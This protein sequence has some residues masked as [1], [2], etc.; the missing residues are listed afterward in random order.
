MTQLLSE[1]K[2]LDLIE[3]Y[4]DLFKWQ[5]EESLG[6]LDKKTMMNMFEELKTK[7]KELTKHIK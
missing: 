2:V 4:K 7:I 5:F 6:R 3:Y 1:K